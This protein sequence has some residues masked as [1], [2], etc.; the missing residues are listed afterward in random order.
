MKNTSTPYRLTREL[1]LN[2]LAI[3]CFRDIADEDYISARL[4]YH[5]GLMEPSLWQ[6]QQALEKYLKCI[7]LLHRIP[8]LKLGHSLEEA[9]SLIRSSGQVSLALTPATESLITHIEMYGAERYLTTSSMAFGRHV[10]SLD[11][12]VWELRRFCTLDPAPR[13][14]VLE[15]GKRPRRYSICGLREQVLSKKSETRRALVR[16]NAFWGKGKKTVVKVPSWANRKNAPL[17]MHPEI[18]PMAMKYIHIP[19][20]LARA[21]ENHQAPNVYVPEN[22]IE[23]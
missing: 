18:L 20:N 3:R 13:K 21:Y 6:S 11:R 19:K 22:G 16:E 9:L 1:L 23:A 14:L 12:A 2:D 15:L 4:A 5:H 8:A 17:S 7:L 10:V